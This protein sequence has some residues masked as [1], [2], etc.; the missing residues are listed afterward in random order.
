MI[1]S[2]GNFSSSLFAIVPEGI[3]HLGLWACGKADQ[4]VKKYLKLVRDPEYPD[5]D[6][7]SALSVLVAHW[8]EG[9]LL[10][11]IIRGNLLMT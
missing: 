2:D 5:L 9:W 7:V 10:V 8:V 6:A 4:G 3:E 1:L 11:S